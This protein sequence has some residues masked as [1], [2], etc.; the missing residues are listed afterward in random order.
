MHNKLT[1]VEASPL[2]RPT[3]KRPKAYP[4]PLGRH[5]RASLGS[6]ILLPYAAQVKRLS[7][8]TSAKPLSCITAES[9]NSG[10]TTHHILYT[11]EFSVTPFSQN[12]KSVSV[13]LFIAPLTKIFRRWHPVE[14]FIDSLW[15]HFHALLFRLTSRW[16]CH[17]ESEISSGTLR[18]T[19]SLY[20]S[21]RP[22]FCVRDDGIDDSR[23]MTLFARCDDRGIVVTINWF[24]QLYLFQC[25]VYNWA[26]SWC[27]GKGYTLIVF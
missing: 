21:P 2:A 14:I 7:M 4:L 8:L 5:P 16:F 11:R 23:A 15:K 17:S 3:S 24:V 27:F 19:N 13:F 10:I 26:S 20:G 9:R 6:R 25:C 1:G 18:Y 12:D 22:S